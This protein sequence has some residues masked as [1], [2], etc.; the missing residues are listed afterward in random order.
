MIII[1]IKKITRDDDS[2][3]NIPDYEGNW[4]IVGSIA[5][6]S[7]G[8]NYTVYEVGDESVLAEYLASLPQSPPDP[9]TQEPTKADLLAELADLQAKIE[10]L[11]E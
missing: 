6:V 2:V 5:T 1:P 8:I 3:A 7:D 9:P 11:K 4:P 10:A